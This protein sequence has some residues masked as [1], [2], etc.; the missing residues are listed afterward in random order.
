MKGRFF[1]SNSELGG[2]YRL[3]LEKHNSC[4]VCKNKDYSIIEGCKNCTYKN[5]F[6]GLFQNLSENPE[7]QAELIDR[8]IKLE[9]DADRVKII[10]QLTNKLNKDKDRFCPK[11]READY[12]ILNG[13]SKCGYLN[14]WVDKVIAAYASYRSYVPITEMFYFEVESNR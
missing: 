6:I 12:M 11:C 7:A 10:A 3:K 1:L 13:C 14:P 2:S 8:V 5:R 4:P 9:D